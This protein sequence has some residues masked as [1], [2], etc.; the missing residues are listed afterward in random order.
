MPLRPHPPAVLA[1]SLLLPACGN[2]SSRAPAL[3]GGSAIG[4]GLYVPHCQG[5][6]GPSGTERGDAAGAAERDPSSAAST[7]LGGK[8]GMPTFAGTLTPE[9]VSELLAYLRT[10]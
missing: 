7:I 3:S 9:Q 6:H 5:C 1:L 8:A 10:L 2:A 4:Q